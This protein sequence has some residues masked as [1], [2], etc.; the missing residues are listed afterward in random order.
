[1]WIAGAELIRTKSEAPLDLVAR[2]I[3]IHTDVQHSRESV[4]QRL[5]PHLRIDSRPRA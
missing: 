5:S 4:M 1:V 2:E 3:R